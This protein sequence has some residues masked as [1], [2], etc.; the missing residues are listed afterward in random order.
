[1]RHVS[2]QFFISLPPT[3]SHES[4]QASQSSAQALQYMACFSAKHEVRGSLAGLDAISHK[5]D[6]F[7]FNMFAAHFKISA[8]KAWFRI[9]RD[10]RYKF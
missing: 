1:M 10:T 7:L 9:R 4:A 2:A 3:S 8:D 5:R 6:V